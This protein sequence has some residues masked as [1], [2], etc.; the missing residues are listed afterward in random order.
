[1]ESI[2]RDKVLDQLKDLV[3]RVNRA[4]KLAL[5]QKRRLESCYGEIQKL[6]ERILTLENKT[7]PSSKELWNLKTRLEMAKGELVKKRDAHNWAS[8]KTRMTYRGEW[9]LFQDA[10]KKVAAL[11]EEISRLT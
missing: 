11:E 2:Q 8:T 1:M 5:E 3:Q 9:K 7:P 10:K 4:G 6:R